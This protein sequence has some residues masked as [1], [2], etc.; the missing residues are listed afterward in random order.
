MSEKNCFG[1]GIIG[2]GGRGSG[3]LDMLLN[4]DDIAVP[5]VCDLYEDRARQAADRVEASGRPRPLQ[6]LDYRD[7]LACPDV[8]GVITPSSWTSHLE[9]MLAAMQAGKPVA[10][11]VGG[12]TSVQECWD[13]VHAAKATD[14]PCMMLENCCY[15]REEMALLNMVRQGVFGELIHCQGGYEHDLRAEVARGLENRHYRF[16]NYQH[17]NGDIYPTHALGPIAKML[18]INRGNRFVSLA[19]FP[20][21]KRGLKEWASA[22]LD[23]DHA[24]NQTWFNQADVVTTV[25]TCARG[26]T[27]V[28][29]HDTT[30]PRPYSRGGRVQ[31]TRGIWMED[32]RSIYLEGSSP[33]DSWEPF[34]PYLETYDHPL[35]QKSDV[36]NYQAGHG[37]MDYLVLRAFIEP[38]MQGFKQMPIDVWDV[39]TWMAVTP[40][41][42][43]SVALGGQPVAFPDFTNGSWICRQI[44]PDHRYSLD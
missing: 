22:N 12:A 21:K 2:L 5:A 18:D 14:V 23:A 40:L 11:E 10:T 30:L 25:L 27:V 17:R 4:M 29:T 42:E 8:D 15:G 44:A 28:L 32:N 6:T 26:E 35:W 16:L 43:E 19:S 34:A 33:N 36:A 1:I 38:L 37:G 39:A 24:A 3:L 13:L 41:S 31:G 9:I 20:T 7:V